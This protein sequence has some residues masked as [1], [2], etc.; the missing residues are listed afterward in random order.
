MGRPIVLVLGGARSGKSE[1]AESMVEGLG[2]TV[3]YLATGWTPDGSDPGWAARVAAHRLRRSPGWTTVEVG[4]DLPGS[5][6]AA[7][8]P[9]LV[10]SLG[11]WVAGLEGFDVDAVSLC[12]ALVARSGPTVLVSDE[13]GFGVSPPTAAGNTFRDALG[14]L[15]RAVSHVADEAWLIV[16]GRR[17]ALD[18]P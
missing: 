3:T 13:V 5:L 7:T 1:I 11:T 9:V 10:D 16:A 15:N 17:L 8:G 2:P 6:R 12:D 14:D 4:E 18:R